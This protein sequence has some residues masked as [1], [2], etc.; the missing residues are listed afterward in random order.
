MVYMAV[1]PPGKGETQSTEFL[2]MPASQL[3]DFVDT[4]AKNIAALPN[5]VIRAA[6]LAVPPTD[7]SNGYQREHDTWASLFA[8]PAAEKLIRGGMERGAQ[9]VDGELN[10]EALLRDL[11]A[12][13]I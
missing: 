1:Y 4:I 13:T 3:D 12:T 9:T 5:S 10:L 2:V 7:L 11:A 6:K 8:L